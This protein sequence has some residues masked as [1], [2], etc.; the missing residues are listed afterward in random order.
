MNIQFTCPVCSIPFSRHPCQVKTAIP[1]CSKKC[2]FIYE[3]S[4]RPI[5]S[6]KNCNN[7]VHYSKNKTVQFCCQKC[8][9][10]YKRKATH[11]TLLC[12]ACN[13]EFSRPQSHIISEHCFCSHKCATKFRDTKRSSYEYFT[14]FKL[15]H[16]L[17]FLNIKYN[18]RIEINQS[19]LELDIVIP[20]LKLVIE[21]NG[22]FHKINKQAQLHDQLKR[23]YCK[24]EK[25][26]LVQLD[27]TNLSR[28]ECYE[29]I[30][31]SIESRLVYDYQ[32]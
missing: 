24:K 4:L 30:K 2:R 26:N 25:V 18:V 16:D 27:I 17:A 8:A 12:A 23:E 9:I 11:R 29:Q 14:E 32:I 22:I 20:S 6:C 7:P 28:E 3:R 13:K 31:T 19:W 15:K 10:E 21:I 1:T 5:R